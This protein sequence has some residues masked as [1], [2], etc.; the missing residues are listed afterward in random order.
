[1][2]GREGTAVP[3]LF[4][5]ALPHLRVSRRTPWLKGAPSGVRFGM[6]ARGGGSA[7]VLVG[8]LSFRGFSNFPVGSAIPG[9]IFEGGC[10]RGR[11]NFSVPAGPLGYSSASSRCLSGGLRG[12]LV[13][14]R[15]LGLLLAGGSEGEAVSGAAATQDVWP[16]GHLRSGL[17]AARGRRVDL[18]GA[19]GEAGLLASRSSHPA[20]RRG[21]A[22]TSS[23]RLCRIG[24]CGFVLR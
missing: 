7:L 2:P 5:E 22:P 24:W 11:W 23:M 12:R 19:S 17:A 18:S 16:S 10:W 14:A 15:R 4:R 1:L 8:L 9:G 3:A 20:L 21:S 13:V 6:W